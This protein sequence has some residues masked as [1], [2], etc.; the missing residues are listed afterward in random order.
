MY[1]D[2]MVKCSKTISRCNHNTD[3]LASSLFKKLGVTLKQCCEIAEFILL[4]ENDAENVNTFDK[5]RESIITVKQMIENQF[6]K[7][8]LKELDPNKWDKPALLTL[9]SDIKFFR[10]H[11]IFVERE[12]Y[13]K[14]K[15]NPDDMQAYID[16]QESILMQIELLNRRRTEEVQYLYTAGRF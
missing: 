6:S 12:S 14:L 1:Y 2:V 16:F 3:S 10:D 13:Y 4:K 8:S 7:N 15:S 11:L 5:H 9:T